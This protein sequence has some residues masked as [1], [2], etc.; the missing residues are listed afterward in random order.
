MAFHDTRGIQTEIMKRRWVELGTIPNRD[1]V[2]RRDG[3]AQG[4]CIDPLFCADQFREG[5]RYSQAYEHDR[6]AP[7]QGVFRRSRM[8]FLDERTGIAQPR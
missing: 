4:F 3:L 5:W 7:N 6:A 2:A 1:E 8:P